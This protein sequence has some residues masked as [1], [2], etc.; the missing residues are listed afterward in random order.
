MKDFPV[1]AK[2][3]I[4]IILYVVYVLF[5][6]VVFS[7]VFPLILQAFG[8]EIIH[9][10]D[11][12]YSKIQYFI[13]ILVLL[14]SLVFRKH[15]YVSLKPEQ[16]EIKVEVKESYTASKK[17]QVNSTKAKTTAKKQ[18]PKKSK[19]DEDIKIYVEKEIK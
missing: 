1:V 2:V 14:V 15:F 12:V 3:M 10:S 9:P 19:D 6:S 11:P 13:V 4:N 17:K 16:E 18:S 8:Q 7:F 5:V